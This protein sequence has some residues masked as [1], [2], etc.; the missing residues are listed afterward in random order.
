MGHHAFSCCSLLF[1]NLA[2]P[3][4]VPVVVNVNV[5]VDVARQRAAS[6]KQQAAEHPLDPH[7]H[8]TYRLL[9]LYVRFLDAAPTATIP[10]LSISH[11]PSP[12]RTTTREYFFFLSFLIPLLP[13]F[14]IYLIS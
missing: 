14:T 3:V 4:P 6:S 13:P 10:P 9:L 7:I 12:L 5:D 11:N 8:I 2:V 1:F